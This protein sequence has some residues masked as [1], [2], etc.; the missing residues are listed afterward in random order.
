MGYDFFLSCSV[1]NQF[2]SILLTLLHTTVMPFTCLFSLIQCILSTLFEVRL[3]NI[4]SKIILHSK[5]SGSWFFFVQYMLAA[6]LYIVGDQMSPVTQTIQSQ[7]CILNTK[8]I[9]AG[10]KGAMSQWWQQFTT[11]LFGRALQN[12]LQTDGNHKN[13][14]LWQQHTQCSM[15]T[16]HTEWYLNIS[17]LELRNQVR[18]FYILLHCVLKHTHG[19][20]ITI[21]IL[22]VHLK[23]DYQFKV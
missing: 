13:I 23:S 14:I 20:V 6:A 21:H 17:Y 15:C 2:I 3:K 5:T 22:G 16:S 8:T 18:K 1:A 7:Q 9:D 11:H 10:L 12:Y 19:F 4:Q